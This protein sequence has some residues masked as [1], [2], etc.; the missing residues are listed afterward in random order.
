MEH[1]Y[2]CGISD[3][4]ALLSDVILPDKIDKICRRCSHEDGLPLIT[5]TN[6]T[7]ETEP[8]L[9]VRERL[10]RLSKI[11]IKNVSEN[12][13]LKREETK[14]KEIVNRNFRRTVGDTSVR[15]DLVDN[16]H[17]FIMRAR[18]SQHMYQKEL[19]EEIKESED[20][21]RMAER[22]T[23]SSLDVVRKIEIALSIR[24]RK[25]MDYENPEELDH[26]EFEIKE[27]SDKFSLDKF[28]GLNVNDLK[29]M[30]QDKEL[31]VLE[32]PVEFSGF[33]DFEE[34]EELEESGKL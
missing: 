19:A 13:D 30:K 32:E 28:K 9:T 26:S 6:I 22:G 3:A 24:L 31:E 29:E 21:V 34:F 4:Q 23:V 27:S 25:I 12:T 33:E 17:W 10:S 5:K 2:K 15:E 8:R 14:L 7:E 11:P 1:C 18:R 20:L 16:F